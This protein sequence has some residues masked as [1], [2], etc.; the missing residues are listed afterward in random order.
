MNHLRRLAPLLLAAFVLVL[1]P[2]TARAENAGTVA[3]ALRSSPVYQ[4]KGLDRID[5]ATAQGAVQGTAPQIYVAVLEAGAAASANEAAARASDIGKA[6][7]TTD[8]V[9]LV[10]TDSR[11]LGAATGKDARSRGADGGAAL[12]QELA[13]IKG[14]PFDKATVTDFVKAFAQRVGAQASNG[15]TTANNNNNASTPQKASHSGRNFLLVLLA[16]GG[17]GFAFYRRSAKK[18]R[19]RD[20]QGLRADVESLY[21]RLGSDVSTLDAKG[22]QLALQALSDASERY[23]ATGSALATADTPG[24]FAAARRTAVEGLVAAQTAR[25]QLG[26][27]P[28]PEIPLPPGNGPQLTGE[29]RVR[30]GDQEYDGS[31]NYRP[32]NGH[33]YGGGNVNGQMVPGG[34]YSQPFWTPFLLGS[35]LS[36]G[37]GGG[38]LF[39]GGLFGGGYGGGGYERGYEEG[40]ENSQDD[41]R[42]DGGG[43]GDWGGGGGG[44][45]G[46]D[47]GGG[48]GDGGGGGGGDW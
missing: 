14:K 26:L 28:G 38:G 42:G 27:D 33:Y 22:D 41:Y 44:G 46:G 47:W 8:A 4:A 16:L 24:E 12:T 23:N 29:Q 43:G 15:G 25:K 48:G 36:G 35:V 40:R 45:G 1:M 37:L 2:G 39:G 6:L 10:I 19:D 11:H 13:S 17:G 3:Q 9:V 32:G 31:P 34:W 20:N 30:F 18:K 7:G 5:V 21:N